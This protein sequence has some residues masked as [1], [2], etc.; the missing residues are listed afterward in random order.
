MIKFPAF[1]SYTEE[2]PY[3]NETIEVEF[4]RMFDRN[5]AAFRY[6]GKVY[7]IRFLLIDIPL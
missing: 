7:I 2:P 5:T 1:N 6:N 4:V 3:T